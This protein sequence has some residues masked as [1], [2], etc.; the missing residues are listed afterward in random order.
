M[1]LFRFAEAITAIA[2]FSM[3]FCSCKKNAISLPNIND[4]TAQTIDTN[5]Y[6]LTGEMFRKQDS[7]F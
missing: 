1:K 6:K 3:I 2:I 5:L 4:D 7:Y